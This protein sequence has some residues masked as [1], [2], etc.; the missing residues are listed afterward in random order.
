MLYCEVE[1][2]WASNTH[3]KKYYFKDV[4]F[5]AFLARIPSFHRERCKLDQCLFQNL[6]EIQQNFEFWEFCV[7]RGLSSVFQAQN[8]DLLM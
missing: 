1:K 3:L 5:A 8:E 6:L 4:E 7:I 2:N